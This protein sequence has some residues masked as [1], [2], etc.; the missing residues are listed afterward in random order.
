MIYESKVLR[1]YFG[2]KAL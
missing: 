1:E 2:L